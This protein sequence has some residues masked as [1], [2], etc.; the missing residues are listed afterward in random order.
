MKV[1]SEQIIQLRRDHGWSQEELAVSAGLNLRTVQRI[2]KE[3]VISLQSKKALASVFSIDLSTLD[4]VE[5]VHTKHFEYKTVVLK[6]DVSWISGWGKKTKH[7]ASYEVD[8][9]LN[10]FAEAGWRVHTVNHG[11]SVHGGAGQMQVLLEREVAHQ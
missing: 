2:E 4:Y 3:G 11:S 1:D 6:N 8:T 9:I 7:D 10:T 5:P